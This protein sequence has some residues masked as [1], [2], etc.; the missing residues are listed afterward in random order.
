MKIK[1]MYMIFD[2]NNQIK[3]HYF[4][5]FGQAQCNFNGCICLGKMID[6]LKF[7]VDS[8]EKT[9][10]RTD[11]IINNKENLNRINIL[12]SKEDNLYKSY[13]DITHE[14]LTNEEIDQIQKDIN[15]NFMSNTFI[16]K[17]VELLESKEV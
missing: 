5:T 10:K 11:E 4:T 13:Y 9:K 6:S 3:K 7:L 8:Y 2:S 16:D 12:E 1:E 17:M 15:Y 14:I